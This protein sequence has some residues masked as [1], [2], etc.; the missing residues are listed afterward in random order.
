MTNFISKT[1]NKTLVLFLF[2][3]L[4]P[5]ACFN[6]DEDEPDN[7]IKTTS[8]I[9]I[10]FQHVIGTDTLDFDKFLYTNKTGNFYSISKLW[11]TVSDFKFYNDEGE[12]LFLLDTALFVDARIQEKH[13]FTFNN[14]PEGQ[15]QTF[16]FV[17]GVVP[18]K[19]NDQLT[20]SSGDFIK[21]G[22]LDE[23]GGG[24]HFMQHDGRVKDT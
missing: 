17:F 3:M 24:V 4:G 9:K 8:H 11:Y 12:E 16:T 5:I 15:Y 18:E 14:A 22:W 23:L 21:F 13:S 7:K 10:I 6:G 1:D 19:N 20:Y 2:I